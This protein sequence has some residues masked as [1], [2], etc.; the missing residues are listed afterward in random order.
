[1][2]IQSVT[3][4]NT[5]TDSIKDDIINNNS[6]KITALE[7]NLNSSMDEQ[8]ETIVQNVTNL[9]GSVASIQT[10]LTSRLDNVLAT[11]SSQISS[12]GGQGGVVIQYD[13]ADEEGY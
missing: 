2:N 4:V 11:L 12:L 1:M 7:S 5:H 3:D 10:A 9:A 6:A 13:S 8:T